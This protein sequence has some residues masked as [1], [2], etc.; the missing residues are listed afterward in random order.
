M[1]F[2]SHL[3][4][5]RVTAHLSVDPRKLGLK[6]NL[7]RAQDAISLKPI[8]LVGDGFDLDFEGMNYRLVEIES[9]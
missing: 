6:K 1:L 7:V 4:R 5:E 2:V 8:P 9:R 3:Q